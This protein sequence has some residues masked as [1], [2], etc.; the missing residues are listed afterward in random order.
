MRQIRA[1]LPEAISRH[2]SS[3]RTT[4]QEVDDEVDLIIGVAIQDFVEGAIH[5]AIEADDVTLL[6]GYTADEHRAPVIRHPIA[7]DPPTALEPG[8]N[9]CHRGQVYADPAGES[10]RADRSMPNDHVEAVEI[11]VLDLDL[12]PDPMVEHR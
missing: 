1:V 4:P 7:Y 9:A 3:L 11:D 12:G 6:I 2:L 8:K 5:A 10:S